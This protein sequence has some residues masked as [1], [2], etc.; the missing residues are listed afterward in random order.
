MLNI[1]TQ[2]NTNTIKDFIID[3]VFVLTNLV[4]EITNWYIDKKA[5]IELD[6]EI[7]KYEIT[8]NK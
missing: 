1:S 4:S 5:N 8:T 2:Y 7:I 3:L 6:Y